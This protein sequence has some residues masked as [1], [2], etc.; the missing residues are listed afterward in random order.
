MMTSMKK[1]TTKAKTPLSRT[2]LAK[3]AAN[4]V[5]SGRYKQHIG[6]ATPAKS[7]MYKLGQ[8]VVSIDPW[9][10]CDHNLTFVKSVRWPGGGGY[11]V[12]DKFGRPF[13]TTN[14]RSTAVMAQ[15]QTATAP[16]T[17]KACKKACAKN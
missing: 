16:T 7:R 3:R 9:K 14:I 10:I 11:L 15:M 2:M 12:M 17:Q 4:L 13:T 8:S 5:K 1:P 6:S